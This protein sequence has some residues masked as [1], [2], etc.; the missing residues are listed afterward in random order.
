[1][2]DPVIDWLLEA[3]NPSVRYL[4]LTSLLHRPPDDPV[5]QAARKAIMTD[6]LVPQILASQNPDG[7]WE[8]P[9]KFYT[10]KYTGTVWTFWDI[11]M[12]GAPCRRSIG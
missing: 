4:T 1:M 10:L 6:G 3:D 12:T 9:D 8:V 11:W 2:S 7:S 5:C